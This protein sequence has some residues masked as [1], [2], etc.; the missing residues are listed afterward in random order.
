MVFWSD[1]SQNGERKVNGR[2]F[3]DAAVRVLFIILSPSLHF[4]KAVHAAPPPPELFASKEGFLHF[5]ETRRIQNILRSLKLQ[6]HFNE[7]CN[8]LDP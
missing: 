4:V 5:T 1:A 8:H 3:G 7:L 6:T 2:T